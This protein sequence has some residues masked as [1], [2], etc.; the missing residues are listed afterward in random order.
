MKHNMRKNGYSKK[1]FY[2]E[3]INFNKYT[4]LDTLKYCLGAT[5][6]MPSSK[7][8]AKK[9]INKEHTGLT[10]VAM[11]FEDA[12]REEDLEIAQT[13][14]IAILDEFHREVTNGNITIDDLPLYFLRVRN[15]NQF[16]DFTD[17]L[18]D[19][20][21]KY[22][23]GF[24]FP[25]FDTSN[26]LDYLDVLKS[27]NKNR[28]ELVYGLP[29]LE[30]KVI[31]NIETRRE[32]LIELYK[33]INDN[34][35]LI[36]NIRVGATDFSSLFG[37]RRSMDF[38]IYDIKPIADCLSDII[39]VFGRSEDNY[40]LSAPVWEYFSKN[41]VLKPQL[42]KK[43]FADNDILQKRED[44]ID[45]AIDGLIKEVVLDKA[46]GFV[47][48][49]IIH[50]SHIKYVNAMQAITK[51]EYLDATMIIE[52]QGGGVLKGASGNKMNE[53]NPHLNWAKKIL[54]RGQVY[55]VLNNETSYTRLF[56]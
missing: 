56:I 27:V 42:R 53:T 1:V 44:M 24:I 17:R 25:K 21:F 13:N 26:A 46:N 11:C 49:T 38:S 5:L 12:I 34:K 4:D 31:M 16:K 15:V 32:E 55:G 33:I 50:P 20:H 52:N 2:K 30:S 18:K 8:I 29:I 6:Y 48:K 47:G 36:L 3:P 9:L 23:T 39:N 40:V 28:N 10:S 43:P 22:I 51:E 7:D 45:K 37:V 54:I 14:V 35:N 41:R 19:Y